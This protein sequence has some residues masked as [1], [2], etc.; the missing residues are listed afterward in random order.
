MGESLICDLCGKHATVHLTQI[1]NNQIQKVDLCEECAQQKGVTDPDGFSLAD[2]LAK[3]LVEAGD[4]SPAV[5]DLSCATC[6]CTPR[7]FKKRGRLGCPSCYRDL[8]PLI[9]PMLSGIH[10]DNVHRGKIPH[11]LIDRQA[12]QRELKRL[13]D[14]LQK[15]INDE[16]YEDAVVFRD[17]L[18]QLREADSPIEKTC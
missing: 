16:R 13:N 9:Y 18:E 15:A 7:D 4:E 8:A 1:I 17:Q 10:R 12:A 6:G 5:A 2:V 11:Q 14:E 3:N